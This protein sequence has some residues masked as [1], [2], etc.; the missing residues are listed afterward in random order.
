M[1]RPQRRYGAAYAPGKLTDEDGQGS[2]NDNYGATVVG[3]SLDDQVHDFLPSND[4][5]YGSVLKGAPM[6][7]VFDLLGYAGVGAALLSGREELASALF[8]GVC[9]EVLLRRVSSNFD[10][11]MEILPFNSRVL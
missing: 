7:R 5:P 6:L 2:T 3:S 9:A 10:A 4:V 8:V 1:R 11:A